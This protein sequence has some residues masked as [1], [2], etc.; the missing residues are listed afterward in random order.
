MKLVEIVRELERWSQDAWGGGEVEMVG[1]VL[2]P[3]PRKGGGGSGKGSV[4]RSLDVSCCLSSDF[5]SEKCPEL[6][7]GQ[8]S[9]CD[10]FLF[11]SGCHLSQLYLS[12]I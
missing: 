5:A 11:N 7:K 1:G 9:S 10:R 3:D 4:L 6:R 12:C 8:P 2:L